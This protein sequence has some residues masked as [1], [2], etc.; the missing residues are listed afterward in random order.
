MTSD[1]NIWG[2]M[3]W[4][5]LHKIAAAYPVEPTEKDKRA[6]KARLEKF[7][8]EIPCQVC[9]DHT[10][11]YFKNRPPDLKSRLDFFVYTVTFH[12]YVNL[13]LNKPQ[14]CVNQAMARYLRDS[15]TTCVLC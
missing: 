9:R 15:P 6:M 3:Y 4:D 2:P 7:V 5:Y 10:R 8:V 12:N 13:T 11:E 1:K 14:F